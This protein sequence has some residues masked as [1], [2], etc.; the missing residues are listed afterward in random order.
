[1]KAILGVIP[2]LCILTACNTQPA[3]T[4]ESVNATLWSLT[5]PE[6]HA[7]ATQAY[8]AATDSLDAALE[9]PRWTAALEQEGNYA[10][11]PPAVMMD[12]DQTILD[13]SIYNARIVTEYGEYTQETFSAWCKEVA[14]AAIPGAVEFIDYAGSR[15]VTVIYY[16]RRI[17]PLRECTTKNMEALGIPVE[18]EFLL[19]NNRRPDSKKAYLR[20]ELSSR[21]RILLL[22]GDDLE[23]FVAGTRV[24][25]AARMALVKQHEER[26]GRQWIVLPNPMYGAWDT[27]LYGHNYE[28]SRE[29]KLE[30]KIRHL[31]R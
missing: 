9:D 3:G 21:F 12:I 13:N 24:D 5:A 29:E 6:F 17:E 22:V 19:L 7:G 28:L 8:R 31:E 27:S 30:L 16:S 4:H 14:A 15:G 2:L 26:W 20:T 11:L 18:Q 1:M 10:D 23:D 25:R